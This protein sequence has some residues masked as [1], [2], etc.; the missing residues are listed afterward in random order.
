MSKLAKRRKKRRSN[1]APEASTTELATNAAVGFAGYAGTRLLARMVFA[2]V[3]KRFPGFAK[4]AHVLASAAAAGG[5]YLGTR[6]VERAAEHHEAATIGAGIA[7]LQSAF[8]TYAPA[9]YSFVTAD[10][11]QGD[12]A[13]K[14]A[15]PSGDLDLDQLLLE[16][17]DLD[18]VEVGRAEPVEDPNCDDGL[19]DLDDI[20]NLLEFPSAS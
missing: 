16:N 3:S 18:A 9:R 5:V 15:P 19:D 4:H 2:Q 10:V 14:K 13:K 20:D 8:Q 11:N 12:Y 6:Y 17:P 1:P 7:V